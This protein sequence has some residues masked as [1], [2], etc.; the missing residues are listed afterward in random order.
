MDA[1][2]IRLGNRAQTLRARFTH[3]VNL[4]SRRGAGDMI[5]TILVVGLVRR[6]G[7]RLDLCIRSQDHRDGWRSC[8]EVKR[9]ALVI[10]V[11]ATGVNATASGTQAFVETH[12]DRVRRRG[13]QM[14][15]IFAPAGSKSQIFTMQIPAQY[16]SSPRNPVRRRPLQ[17]PSGASALTTMGCRSR[18]GFLMSLPAWWATIGVLAGAHLLVLVAGGQS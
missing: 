10:W 3:P 11:C 17:S 1:A 5:W 2:A 18:I 12:A 6:S 13:C 14:R 4:R 8:V 15:C 9:T 16:P 7:G